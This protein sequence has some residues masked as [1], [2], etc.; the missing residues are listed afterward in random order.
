MRKLIFAAALVL[1]GISGAF[2][3][4]LQL[5][6][7]FRRGAENVSAPAGVFTTTVEMF[8]PDK[9]GSTFFFVDM[10]YGERGVKGVS[11]A[12]WEIARSLKFWDGPFAA[13]VEYNGG[14]GIGKGGGY[15]GFPIN[16]A[17]L[18]GADYVWNNESF[19]KGFTLSAMYK[20]I[21][22]FGSPS[23]QLT[24][25][26]YMHLFNNKFTF[27]GFADFWKQTSAYGKKFVFLSEPQVWFNINKNF[28]VGS[29]LEC[30]VNF[31]RKNFAIC[32]TAA[33]KYNF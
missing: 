32:P 10:N 22:G 19:T 29:E 14:Q 27:S 1:C 21:Q 4:N 16:D 15:Y 31:Y 23:F 17:W 9:H 12:Y 24:G 8:K 30:S 5:H 11:L 20:Y 25:V 7:D 26:W 33:V 18:F 13:H 3:Q 28:S 6:Y 2:A